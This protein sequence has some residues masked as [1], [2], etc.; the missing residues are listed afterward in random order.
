MNIK[1]L[2]ESMT[3]EDFIL[4]DN[5]REEVFTVSEEE[6]KAT[7]KERIQKKESIALPIL[8]KKWIKIGKD[9]MYSTYFSYLN[10]DR[11]RFKSL[12]GTKDMQADI[13]IEAENLSQGSYE[14]LL[15]FVIKYDGN[16]LDIINS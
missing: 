12:L 2:I 15:D 10:Q 6:K 3:R 1:K 13:K 7:E 8:K 16:I 9:D 4:L 11:Q 5:K 14:D